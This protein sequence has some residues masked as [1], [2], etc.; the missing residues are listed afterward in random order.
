MKHSIRRWISAICMVVL[1]IGLSG[2][3]LG[4][5]EIELI[6]GYGLMRVNAYA[7][8]VGV[9]PIDNKEIQEHWNGSNIVVWHFFVSDVTISQSY[10]GMRGIKTADQSTA[11]KEELTTPID[12]RVYYLLDTQNHQLYGPYDR[13][14]YLEICMDKQVDYPEDWLSTEEMDDWGAEKVLGEYWERRRG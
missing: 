10:I 12:L 7:I 9:V 4:D 5:W 8:H 6:N 11:S 1:L 14:G 2:C 13:E 3:G